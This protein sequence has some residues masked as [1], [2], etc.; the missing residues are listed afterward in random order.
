MSWTL[1]QQP[2]SAN[3][4]IIPAYNNIV[5]KAVSNL[6]ASGYTYTLTLYVYNGAVLE[7]TIILTKDADRKSTRLNSSH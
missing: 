1:T 2:V 4:A 5:F 3:N 7:D 6:W